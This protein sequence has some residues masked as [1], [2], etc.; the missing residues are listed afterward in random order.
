MQCPVCQ[1]ENE[2]CKVGDTCYCGWE[3]DNL[4]PDGWSYAN[5]MFLSDAIENTKFYNG[6]LSEVW[7]DFHNKKGK[8]NE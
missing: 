6:F 2:N 5:N 4:E 3:F 1:I 8:D 7:E